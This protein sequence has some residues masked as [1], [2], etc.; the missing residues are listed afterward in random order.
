M[1]EPS[2]VP[3]SRSTGGRLPLSLL[4]G[5][6]ADR[7]LFAPQRAVFDNLVTPDWITPDDGDTLAS[8]AQK[9]ARA[10]DP[11]GPCFVGGISMGGMIALEMTRHLDARACFLISSIRSGRELP[12]RLRAL[13]PLAFLAPVA[14]AAALLFAHAALKIGGPWLSPLRR[15][16]FE[17]FTATQRAFLC[18]ASR[19]ILCWQ[20]GYGE[21]SVPVLHIHGD[22][23]H[24]LPARFTRPD[25]LVPGGGHL[26]TLT[27]PDAVNAFLRDGMARFGQIG[28]EGGT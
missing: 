7:R 8:Y 5:L 27:H 22:R 16:L 15:S 26:L 18:W 13:R 20:P 24:L 3:G 19:A 14:F 11:H 6:G 28:T 1:D 2:I 4:S 17:Q 25:V 12:P 9:M 21:I 23:D 10:V